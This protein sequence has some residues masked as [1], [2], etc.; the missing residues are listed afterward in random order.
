MATKATIFKAQL[1]IADIDHGY[2]AEHALTLARHPSETD[3]RMMVR[4]AALAIQAH[5][6]QALCRGDGTL[7]FGAG[8]SDPDDPD[9]SLTDFSGRRRLWIEVG[10]PDGKPLARACSK[11]DAVLVYCFH[12][13]A[14]VW[15]KGIAAQLSR[16]ERLQVW[17]IPS[18][19][20]QVLAQ[21]AERSMQVQATLQDGSV[22]L[23]SAQGCVLFEPQRWK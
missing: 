3:E 15:W 8:L 4:L 7:A 12:G 19:A 22:A 1:Q 11:A 10:Q 13:A 14:E 17:R 23:S 6:M 2:Y 16:F 21:L 20:S 9:V 5:Q 18:A